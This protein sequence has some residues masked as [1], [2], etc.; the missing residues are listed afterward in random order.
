MMIS[1][2]KCIFLI[3]NI[4]SDEQYF[5]DKENER[6]KRLA[7]K[8]IQTMKSPTKKEDPTQ[9]DALINKLRFKAYKARIYYLYFII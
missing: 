7:E 6:K 2:Y 4:H 3:N 9:N 8:V 1:I 5:I